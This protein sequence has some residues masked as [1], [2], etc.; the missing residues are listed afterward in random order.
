MTGLEIER[1]LYYDS[2]SLVDCREGIQAF[3][4]KRPAIVQHR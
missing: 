4:E 3:L 1:G 2:F